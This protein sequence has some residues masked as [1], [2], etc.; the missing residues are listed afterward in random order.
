MED[1]LRNF[2]S[3]EGDRN[4]VRNDCRG[5]YGR[6]EGETNSG[7]SDS[8][9]RE[10]NKSRGDSRER[11]KKR[12]RSDSREIDRKKDSDSREREKDRGRSDS[13]E[14]ERKR[15]RGDSRERERKRGTSDRQYEESCERGS[16]IIDRVGSVGAE[17][18]GDVSETNDSY[19]R[20][21]AIDRVGEEGQDSSSLTTNNYVVKRESELEP[22]SES[23]SLSLPAVGLDYDPYA[24]FDDEDDENAK[25]EKRGGVV[26]SI[27]VKFLAKFTDGG[28]MDFDTLFSIKRCGK[29]H[30]PK[31]KSQFTPPSKNIFRKVGLIN[32]TALVGP[33][34]ER[35][36][37]A[38]EGV[39]IKVMT[40]FS[41]A[42]R[43]LRRGERPRYECW[44]KHKFLRMWGQVE[45]DW[46]R[47]Q[48][49]EKSREYY[50][51]GER[52][53]D[54]EE[55]YAEEKE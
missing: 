34:F 52:E 32:I 27:L 24:D 50:G 46:E 1:D 8:R 54:D 25:T 26:K 4:R 10:R 20:S 19:V 7:R 23:L 39:S 47:Y 31:F 45:E 17:R 15:G 3:P 9:E 49:R 51:E 38:I 53:R 12:G 42:A 14:R 55:G 11:E 29:Q 37:E 36:V 13:R 18:L 43:S 41:E 35:K 48:K 6:T 28:D 44:N 33:L 16:Y 5:R 40:A 30:N 2:I 21:D 22:G